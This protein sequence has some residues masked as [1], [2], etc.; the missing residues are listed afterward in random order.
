M[1]KQML[2]SVLGLGY[3][4][5]VTLL[6]LIQAGVGTETAN[7]CI[8]LGEILL[9]GIPL[10]IVLVLYIRLTRQI[11]HYK[12]KSENNAVE[13]I[14]ASGTQSNTKKNEEN[15]STGNRQES[16]SYE[17]KYAR[18]LIA[19]QPVENKMSEREMEVAWLL[20][21]GYTNR[22][23]GEALFIAETTVK[24]HVSHIYEKSGVADR[25]EFKAMIG[26]ASRETEKET[27]EH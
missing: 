15:I 10:A 5:L 9:L 6:L 3:V 24:K 4:I 22:Q 8:A 19:A 16:L 17:E 20:Y 2:R 18:F 7:R 21:R 23:I 13:G 12:Y 25:K 1:K 27:E 26:R 14:P 11:E